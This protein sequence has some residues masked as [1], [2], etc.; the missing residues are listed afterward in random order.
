[1]PIDSRDARLAG[2]ARSALAS[3]L[4]FACVVLLA[5]VGASDAYALFIEHPIAVL[6]VALILGCY[7]VSFICL[8]KIRHRAAG[9]SDLLWGASLFAASVPFVA[10][11][12]WLGFWIALVVCFLEVVALAIHVFALADV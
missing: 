4:A 1:V 2:W 9:S 11:I 5:I 3:S 12:Y 8:S 7:I 6:S 10:V